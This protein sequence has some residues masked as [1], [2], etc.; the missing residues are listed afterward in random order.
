MKHDAS[1]HRHQPW[2]AAVP[3]HGAAKQHPA[4]QTKIAGP[5]DRRQAH[6]P[7]ANDAMYGAKCVCV[8]HHRTNCLLFLVGNQR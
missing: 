5:P 2:P 3:N 7:A 8:S 1:C 4:G 6:M